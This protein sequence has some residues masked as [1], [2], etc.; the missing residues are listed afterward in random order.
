MASSPAGM[1]RLCMAALLISSLFISAC[2]ATNDGHIGNRAIGQDRVNCKNHSCQ[3]HDTPPANQYNRGC[4]I[5]H[6]CRQNGSSRGV[7]GRRLLRLLS[8]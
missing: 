1:I 7:G 8:L 3:Q 5:S 6:R 4:E 2:Q